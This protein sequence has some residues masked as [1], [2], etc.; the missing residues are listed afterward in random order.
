MIPAYLTLPRGVPAKNLP[1]IVNIHGGPMV[2][3]YA[4]RSGD[5]GRKRSS[6]PRTGYAVLEAEPRASTGYGYKLT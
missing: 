2:R 5:A 3:G 4:G 6:S 1:L